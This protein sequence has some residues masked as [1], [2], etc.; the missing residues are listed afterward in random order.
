MLVLSRRQTEQIRI[1]SDVVITV[2][3]IRPHKIRLGIDAPA[4]VPVNREE[5]WIDKQKDKQTP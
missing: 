3:E 2:V 4:N 5:V 1:G